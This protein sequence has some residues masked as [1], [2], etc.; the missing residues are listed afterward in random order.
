MSLLVIAI[1][2][3]SVV[4]SGFRWL[5]VAQREHYIAGCCAMA[6]ARWIRCRPPNSVLAIVAVLAVLATVAS[7]V[8]TAGS[9]EAAS[10]ATAVVVAAIFPWG[11]PIVGSPRFRFTRRAVTLTGIATLLAVAALAL[12]AA[13]LGGLLTVAVVAVVVPLIVDLAAALAAPVERRASERHRRRAQD[14][15]LRCDPFV[16]AVTGSWGKTS[17]KGHIKDLLSGTANI[18]ASPASWN[19][20]AGLS[21]T[22]NEYLTDSTEVLVVEMGMYGPGEIRQL[23]SWVRPNVAVICSIGPMHLERVGSLEGIVE[24]KAEILE[25]ADAAVLWVD[26]KL[27]ADLADRCE[28]PKVWRV[29]TKGGEHLDV[30]VEVDAE[31]EEIVVFAGEVRIGACPVLS[32]A[33]AGNI[34]CAVAAAL[35][36]GATPDQIGRQLSELSNPD[37]RATAGTNDSGV[38]VIDDT[39][40]SNPAGALSAVRTLERTVTG[41]RVVITPGMVELG[42]V[43]AEENSRLAEAVVESGARLIVVGWTNRRAL[44]AGASGRATTVHDRKAALEWVRRHLKDGDGVLWEN[45]LPDHYP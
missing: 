23:C 33:H 36:Y 44:E 8:V 16:I 2:L 37:H 28:V 12:G 43:Q 31:H 22:M 26:D 34:G 45:D 41:D 19:N 3:L 18:V 4:L 25:S 10:A 21:R 27:L 39:F 35:A 24:A 7:R 38:L 1:G 30:A 14:R 5:R 11:M 20:T 6:A 40:N 17:T 29:G 9:A 13:L 42:R 15:L 32:G